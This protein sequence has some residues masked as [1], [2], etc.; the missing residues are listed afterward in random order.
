MSPCNR[1]MQT[2]GNSVK[3]QNPQGKKCVTVQDNKRVMSGAIL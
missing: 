1:K 3:K 2:G